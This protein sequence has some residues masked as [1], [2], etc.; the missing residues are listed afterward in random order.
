[1]KNIKSVSS[2][3]A[4]RIVNTVLSALC[5]AEDYAIDYLTS[6]VGKECRE[7][8]K[9]HERLSKS[10]E[11]EICSLCEKYE[12]G[13]ENTPIQHYFFADSDSGVRIF[14]G[15]F[16][17]RF[18]QEKFE[19]LHK[20]LLKKLDVGLVYI[21][22]S[23]KFVADEVLKSLWH[24]NVRWE[25]NNRY[26]VF[27]NGVLDT[28]SMRLLGFSAKYHTNMIF[29]Y[30]YN[31]NAQCPLFLKVLSDALSPEEITVLQE[32][33][34][35]L[36]FDDSRFEKIGLLV[37][38]G[39]NGKSVILKAISNAL[40]EDRVTHYSLPQ[41]TE[42]RGVNIADMIGKI[43]NICYDSGS[44]IK[45]GNEALFKQYVS[46]EPMLYKILY[47]QP[48]QTTD[49]P[50]SIM[51][52][53]ELPQSSDFSGGFYR[54]FLILPFDRQIPLDSVDVNLSEKLK[55][56]Q[57]GILLWI[58][59]GKRRLLSNGRFSDCKTVTKIQEQYRT[60]SDAVAYFL[61][62]NGYRASS[63]TKVL[64]SSFYESFKNWSV[65]NGMKVM[66]IR[67]FRERLLYLGYVV[68]KSTG[69]LSYVWVE[70]DD[71]LPY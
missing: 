15:R 55:C 69:H 67:K 8:G 21:Q 24:G 46:G 16:Y 26:F 50:R 42:E 65:T 29:D 18:T 60:E 36:L 27:T 48:S 39:R 25:P 9:C 2:N 32:M 20:K 56:E 71:D 58:L 7:F 63:S 4:E 61:E 44:L 5:K 51:A 33:F 35:Y 70:P 14:N 40:G 49:Y 12:A 38:N 19:Y 31:P 68:R 52:V 17:E 45:I 62:E 3:C 59:E 43:A 34:G 10:T 54:R 11:A 66:S 28:D 37:G 23:Y 13:T 6:T 30:P 57:M 64:L 41:I 47:R 1:M 53:N 22:N